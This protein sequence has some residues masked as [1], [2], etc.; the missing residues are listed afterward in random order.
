ML[1][2]APIFKL[3]RASTRFGYADDVALLATSPSLEANSQVLPAALQEA[4]EWGTAKGVTFEP[5][6][7]EL[8]HVS[9]KKT[10]QDPSTTPS[11]SAGPIT[12]T[13]SS[14]RPYLRWLGVLFD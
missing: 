3:G 5:T 2:L 8:L 11:V 13:E 1:Y 6:K 9:K 10:D 7:S 12:A 4:L 14:E